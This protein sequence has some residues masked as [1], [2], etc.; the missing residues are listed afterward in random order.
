MALLG[1]DEAKSVAE[2]FT[3][4]QSQLEAP[5]LDAHE[6]LQAERALAYALNAHLHHALEQA[7]PAPETGAAADDVLASIAKKDSES[8][9]KAAQALLAQSRDAL[10][11]VNTLGSGAR[12]PLAA[13]TWARTRLGGIS[14]E[15]ELAAQ[16]ADA[17]PTALKNAVT[18][19]QQTAHTIR[20]TLQT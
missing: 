14:E 11:I 5:E 8:I 7:L 18:E 15:V 2:A 13:F 16:N 19:W 20:T 12:I 1:A 4:L 10:A 6:T 17:N 9:K 3:T